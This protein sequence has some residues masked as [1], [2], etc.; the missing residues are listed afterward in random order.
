MLHFVHCIDALCLFL[1]IEQRD[2][3][4]M[5][6]R[7]RNAQINVCFREVTCVCVVELDV[8]TGLQ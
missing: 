4:G 7:D 2:K 3:K 6:Q 8:N 1:K 5:R